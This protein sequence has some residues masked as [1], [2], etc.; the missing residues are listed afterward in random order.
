MTISIG[1]TAIGVY[2]MRRNPL[3]DGNQPFETLKGDKII[4]VRNQK[5]V[6][7]PTQDGNIQEIVLNESTSEP[8]GNGNYFDRELINQITDHAGN[9]LPEDPRSVIFSHSGLY[10]TSPELRV[11]CTSILH[12]QNRSRNILLGQ[13]GREV[14]G[15]AICSRCDYWLTTIYITLGI[16]GVGLI[17]GLYKAVS[18]L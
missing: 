12:P 16:V 11:I 9:P 2:D 4:N 13:D 5:V 15:G 10:I 3:R 6:R 1:T 17:Y 8:D 7:I 18:S 14:P